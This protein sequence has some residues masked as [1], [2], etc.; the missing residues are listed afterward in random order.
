MD[1]FPQHRIIVCTSCRHK[2]SDCR[3]GHKL[4]TNLRAAIEAAGAVVGD[5]FEVSGVACMAGCDHPC[6][7]AY[8]ATKKATYLFGDID[9][10]EDIDDLV[11]FAEHY[12]ALK[13]GWSTA[14]HWP[15]KLRQN[16]L[17]RVPA[18]MI[19]TQATKDAS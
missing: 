15:Q 18:A 13:D 9:P 17:A 12:H 19:V 11:A 2:G 7:L 4:I 10:N 8:Q 5:D 6:T 1:Q 3:P 14:K 16:T